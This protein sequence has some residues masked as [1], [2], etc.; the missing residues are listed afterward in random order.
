M[1]RQWSVVM[2][3]RHFGYDSDGTESEVRTQLLHAA[4]MVYPSHTYTLLKIHVYLVEGRGL[5]YHDLI[6]GDV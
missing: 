6:R 2:L 5:S 1:E 4:T 3:A